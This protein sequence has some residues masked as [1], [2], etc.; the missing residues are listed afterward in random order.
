MNFAMR[1]RFAAV[2]LLAA[3]LV[4]A[5]DKAQMSPKDV[6]VAAAPAKTAVP[7]K[8]AVP[9]KESEQN[10]FT[11]LL[12]MKLVLIPAGEFQ[13]GA[14]EDVSETLTAFPYAPRNWLVGETPRH[15]VRIT[16]P[17]YMCAHE[18]TLH[19]FLAFYHAAKYKLEA[20]RDG[21]ASW[22]Y[23]SEF[24]FVESRSFR[25]WAPGWE[26]TQDHPVNYVTWN[27][28][29]AFCKWLSE[30]EGKK[31]RLPTEAEWEYACR[32]GS[33]TR[34][35]SGDDPEDL[36]RYGNVAD[37]DMKGRS[38]RSSIAVFKDGKK[39]STTI[40]FPYV[41]RRDGY[42]YTAPFG[43]FGANAYGLYDMHGNVSEW[44]Q[45][46]YDDKYY[47]ESPVDDPK[48]PSKGSMRVLRGGGFNITPVNNRSAQR[49]Y[50]LPSNRHFDVGFRVV[51]EVE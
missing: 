39:T 48:G 3:T 38:Q 5:A 50:E 22:G 17:F 21:K 36:V 47:A 37:Q 15:L 40:P 45:D 2:P 33:T 51:C 6:P 18:T 23:N 19:D 9:V 35:H 43:M 13:M 30:K 1:L 41:S 16:K 27:D 28:A 46:W 7:V 8:A 10:Q 14:D 11:N 31:Y 34:F 29:N 24:R 44:C 25:P 4:H 32:A 49:S 42:P 26:Q 20:E 12:G